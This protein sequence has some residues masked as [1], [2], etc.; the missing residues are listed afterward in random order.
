MNFDYHVIHL[1]IQSV[2]QSV[3]LATKKCAPLVTWLTVSDD[4]AVREAGSE[5]L[6]VKKQEVELNS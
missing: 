4:N 6:N 2:V 5:V 3:K 1:Y